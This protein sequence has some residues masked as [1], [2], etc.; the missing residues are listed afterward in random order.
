MQITSYIGL[1]AILAL[2]GYAH[3]AASDAIST[4]LELAPDPLNASYGIEGRPIHLR[5]GHYQVQAAPGSATQVKTTV[6][7]E[8]VY[9]D[10]GEDKDED[11]VLL[12]AHAPGGS[13]TFYYVAAA[14]NLD[15]QYRGSN[16]VLLGD[17]IAPQEVTI[18]NRVIIANY[19]DRQVEESMTVTP[20]VAKSKYL[21]LEKDRLSAIKPLGKDEQVLEGWVTIGHETRSFWPCSGKT[22]LW[23]L[24]DSPA[25][26]EIIAAYDQALPHPRPYT[27]L[28]MVLVGQIVEGPRE[29]FGAQY[30]GA[31]LAT[32]L[33]QVSPRGNCKSEFIVVEAP[34]PG[35][36]IASPVKIKGK[37]R[38]TWFF[39]GDFP[40]ILTD[41]KGQVIGKS[42][43]TAQ[44]EWMTEKFV[45]FEGTLQ[46]KPP[47]SDSR[48]MLVFKKDNPSGRPEH[49]DQLTVPVF[50]KGKPQCTY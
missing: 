44:G 9:G 6:F 22:D 50:F 14:R 27:P 31:L 19:V 29:G 28:F 42:F 35:A 26:S 1:V 24:G 2:I 20:S 11:A 39:E 23:L 17:R 13:G 5:N 49:D 25:L 45:P 8:P 47:R 3:P 7:G 34:V 30:E 10:L 16:G 18:R 32:Q 48:G 36:L 4:D 15:G 43:A 37:A 46:F 40:L 38:G 12:L 21:T 41:S 33:V